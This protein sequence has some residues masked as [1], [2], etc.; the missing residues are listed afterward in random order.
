MSKKHQHEEE[1]KQ[2]NVVDMAE[3]RRKQFRLKARRFAFWGALI[4]ILLVAGILYIRDYINRV[5]ETMEV[6]SI[7]DW[8]P[9]T[10]ATILPY[11][12]DFVS[13]SS[14]GIHCTNSKGQD[15]WSFSYVMQDPMVEVNGDY[16]HHRRDIHAQPR[17]DAQNVGGRCGCCGFGRYRYHARIPVL[18]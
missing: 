16:V 13:Y 17:T 18:S 9:T 1:E 8:K 12:T 2:N 4:L 10:G 5:Y 15:I 7:V 11:G 6:V 3:F 14:D